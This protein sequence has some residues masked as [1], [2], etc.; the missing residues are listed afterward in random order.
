MGPG[1]H[2]AILFKRTEGYYGSMAIYGVFLD[3]GSR[4]LPTPGVTRNVEFIGDSI[5]CGFGNEAANKDEPNSASNS[6]HYLSYAAIAARR[7]G[8]QHVSVSVSGIR[9]TEAQGLQSMPTV[10]RRTGPRVDDPPWDFGRAPRPDV[11]VVN[12]GT[13]DFH[14][15]DDLKAEE[16][17]RSYNAFLDFIRARRPDAHIFLANGPMMPLDLKLEHLRRWNREVVEQRRAAGD[18]KLYLLDFNIQD[19]SDGFGSG[20]HPSLKTHEK[21]AA[22][23]VSAIKAVTGW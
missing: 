6:N 3:A 7:L 9:L 22:Q 5:T 12:L 16:W 23:L 20:W 18:R 17:E 14:F 19:P 10:Y 21:M 2:T 4:L 13:N 11:V 15:V 8:A 1:E